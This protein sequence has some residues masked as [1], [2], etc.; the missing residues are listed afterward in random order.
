MPN[1]VSFSIIPGEI[2]APGTQIEVCSPRSVDPKAARCAISLRIDGRS[3]IAPITVDKKGTTMK[4]STA[5][6]GP[7]R[8]YLQINKLFDSNGIELIDYQEIP[9]GIDPLVSKVGGSL[10]VIHAAHVA[11]SETILKRL[12]PGEGA[13]PTFNYVGFVKTVDRHNGRIE[14]LAFN[15][16]GEQVDGNAIVEDYKNRRFAKLGTLDEAL[17]DHLLDTKDEENVSIAV[18]P[19]FENDITGYEKPNSGEIREPPAAALVLLNEAVQA[20]STLVSMLKNLGATVEETPKEHLVIY[21]SLKA[22]Q[23]QQFA[24]TDSVLKIFHDDRTGV[25]D[26]G[27]S[28]A[29]AKATQAHALGYTGSGIHVGVFEDGPSNQANLVF[30]GRYMESPNAS[31]HARLTSAIIKNDEPGKPHGYAP[32]CSLYSAN[33]YDNAALR[34]ALS[35][36]QACTVISQSFHRQSEQGSAGMSADDVLKD[37]LATLFPFP[38]IV[39]AAGNISQS[40]E[41]VNHKGFN[42]LS[43]G[44]HND[45]ATAMAGSSVF[46]NPVSPNGDRELPELAANGIGVTALGLTMSGTSFSAP[47][48]AGTAALIQSVDTTHTL[49]NWPEGCRAILLAGAGPNISGGSWKEDLGRIDQSDGSGA[50]NAQM[51]VMIAQQRR[52]R[53]EAA[54]PRGWDVG[55]L[56]TAD[57]DTLTKYSKFSYKVRVPTSGIIKP[58]S[59]YTVKV[60]LAWDGKITANPTTIQTPS[61]DFDLFV[62]SNSTVVA[63]SSS[64]NNSYEIAEFTALPGQAYDIFIVRNQGTDTC[65]YGVAWNVTSRSALLPVQVAGME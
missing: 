27:D 28:E 25:N 15:E 53:N 19:R 14:S 10:R 3:V 56:S 26:L 38:T 7:G 24:K 55:S 49:Q 35:S 44:S 18:W 39:H 50:L 43:V 65:W 59:I 16:R 12:E 54:V 6:L 29:I 20:R 5:G 51:G 22:A 33:S 36:P 48:V 23:I 63:V 45:T 57:F 41:Y 62:K 13:P 4:V 40:P 58:R 30:A 8:F 11:F 21:A 61:V 34:W 46:L 60:A 47:A 37:H 31:D 32:D 2:I 1:M 9:M 42:T 17:Y 52:G 64:Y